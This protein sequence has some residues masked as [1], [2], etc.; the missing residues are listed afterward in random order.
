MTDGFLGRLAIVPLAAPLPKQPGDSFGADLFFTYTGPAQTV[1]VGVGIGYDDHGTPVAY[2]TTSVTL[3]ECLIA[4]GFGPVSATGTV[5]ATATPGT[6]LDAI[7]FAAK[8]APVAGALPDDDFGANGWDEDVYT[9][10]AEMLE[11]L[12]AVYY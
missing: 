12:S 6:S 8:A 1:Y 2:A 5:P 4:T 7:R 11:S 10:F 3:P 9:L